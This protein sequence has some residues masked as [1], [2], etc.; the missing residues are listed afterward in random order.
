MTWRHDGSLAGFLSACWL[1]LEAGDEQAC[2]AGPEPAAGLFDLAGGP[3]GNERVVETR[4]DRARRLYGEM[5]SRGGEAAAL[6]IRDAFLHAAPGGCTELYGALR[7]VLRH[8][9]SALD[10]LAEPAMR[11]TERRCLGVRREAHKLS[12][13]L[14]FR[15]LAGG[16][17]YAPCRPDHAVL[18]LLAPHFRDRLGGRDW[19]IHDQARGQAAIARNGTLEFVQGLELEP[20]ALEDGSEAAFQE[21]WQSFFENIA[22]PERRNPRLQRALM[23]KKYWAG[24]IER[25]G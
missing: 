8:G 15:A 14:R 6:L 1:A 10:R 5:L 17:L 25:P 7:L 18:P 12:G 3:D 4:P 2:P 21:L 23:P 22:V 9:R 13:F 20:D 24:L 16:V 19:I 11:E